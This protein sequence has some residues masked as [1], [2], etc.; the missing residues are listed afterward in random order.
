VYD[1][2]LHVVWCLEYRWP[3]LGGDVAVRLPE[4]IGHKAAERGW[5]VIAPVVMPDH[6]HLFIRHDPRAAAL[7]V[8]NP[9]KGHTSHALHFKFPHLRSRLRPLWSKPYFTAPAGAVS[10]ETVRRYIG[11]RYACPWRRERSR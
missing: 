3:V 11:T 1:L 8:A 4:P 7:Y 6:V 5:D 2:G 9:F 10:A